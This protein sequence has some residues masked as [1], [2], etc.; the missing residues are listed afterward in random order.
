MNTFTL[1]HVVLSLVGIGAG[2]VVIFGLIAAKQLNR[3]TV[4][5]LSTT[6]ATSLTGF[7]FPFHK[8]LPSHVIGVVSLVVL[9]IAILARYV[10]RLVGAWRWIYAVN[11]VIATYLNVFVLIAQLFQKVPALKATAPTQSEPPFLVT[12]LVVM[13]LFVVLGIFAAKRFHT[14]RAREAVAIG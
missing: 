6:V 13:A 7:L 9:A 4:V 12:Q 11:A 5:F 8:L 1:F 3:W 14:E 10:R 2:F